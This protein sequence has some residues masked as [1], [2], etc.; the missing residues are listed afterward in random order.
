MENDFR[1][2]YR[3]NEQDKIVF[4]NPE[5]SQ[6][7]IE[8]DSG[9]LVPENI[10]HQ[11]LWNFISDYTTEHLYRMILRQVRDGR[12]IKFNLRCDAPNFRRF[13]EMTVSLRENDEVQFDA[14]IIKTEE[15]QPPKV[16]QKNIPRKNNL[17]IVC[18]WCNR[19]RTDKENWEEVEEAVRM[20]GL[21][22]L[23]LLPQISHGMCDAC[24]KAIPESFQR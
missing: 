21:F 22:E 1:I 19:I 17:L 7:A 4:V 3:I 12:S 20:L 6:F 24:Y 5:W 9:E 18:S 10:L 15:R 23:E 11:S 2:L 13:L 8:N 14:R 16:L